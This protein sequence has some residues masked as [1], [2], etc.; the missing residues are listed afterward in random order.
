MFGG[1]WDSYLIFRLVDNYFPDPF[2]LVG[3][4]IIILF[5]LYDEDGIF[6]ATLYGDFLWLERRFGSERIFLLDYDYFL[7]IVSG[8]YCLTE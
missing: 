3:R 1:Y 5:W 8:I 2:L 4:G 6:I 7:G